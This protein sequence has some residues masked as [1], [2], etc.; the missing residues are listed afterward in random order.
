MKNLVTTEGCKAE[1]RITILDEM[2]G[3][4]A[5]LATTASSEPAARALWP[6]PL[7]PRSGSR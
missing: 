3:S 7:A 4:G 5:V 2:S 1:P 6:Q